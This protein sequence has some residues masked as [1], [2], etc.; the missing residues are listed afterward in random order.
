MPTLVKFMKATIVGGL[1]F[2]F[3]VALFVVVVEKLVGFLRPVASGIGHAFY[4]LGIG[5]V[6]E[7]AII[8]AAL[9]LV[10][11]VAGLFASTVVGRD[12]L[13][14]MENTLL[15]RFPGY[16][17]VK[18]AAADAAGGLARIDRSTRSNAV[19]VRDG[20]VW[21]IGFVMDQATDDLFTVFIPDAPSPTTGEVRFV[22]PDQFVDSGL[23]LA[24]AIR[25][26]RQLGAGYSRMVEAP[27]P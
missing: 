27:P 14:W 17:I 11:F 19:F 22:G 6:A 24:E 1:F 26:L 10:A 20:D 13:E 21:R 9:L 23:T 5:V 18:T 12:L 4:P 3:P 2:L 8:V 16:N 7:I 25:C 15:G